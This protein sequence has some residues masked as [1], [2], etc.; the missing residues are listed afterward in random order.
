MIIRFW[1]TRYKAETF[2]LRYPNKRVKKNKQRH[3]WHVVGAILNDC[4]VAYKKEQ[5]KVRF[6]HISI[7]TQKYVKK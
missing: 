3:K 6:R 1:K 2:S 5:I 4:V 7:L